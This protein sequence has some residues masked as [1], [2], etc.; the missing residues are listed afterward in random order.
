MSY[1]NIYVA[2]TSQ[3][4]G[5]TT[6]TLGLVHAFLNKSIDVG[7]CKPVGQ[8]FVWH[9]NLQ[10]DKDVV[11]F[12]DLMGFEMDPAVHS[13]VILGPNATSEFLENPAQFQHRER[14]LDASH[15]LQ[16]RHTLRIYEGTGH[17]GVG[18]AVNL[19][20]ADVAK[21]IDAQVIMIAEGGIGS[22]VDMLDMCMA[23]FR[24]RDVPIMGVILNKVLPEKTEKVRYHVG[25]WLEQRGI[26][27]LGCLPYDR[28]MSLPIMR[29]IAESVDGT[30][31]FFPE[32]DNNQIRN[33]IAGSLMSNDELSGKL[34]DS[35][36]VVGAARLDIAIAQVKDISKALGLEKSP[37]SG[38]LATGEGDFKRSTVQYIRKHKIPVVRTVLE[39][40]GAVLKISRI[41]V[42]INQ[43]TPWK[44]ARAIEMIESNVDLD[45]ILRHVQY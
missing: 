34:A 29:T 30:F 10:I 40:Y 42:K 45:Y 27:L 5:K 19:S 1:K 25:K 8:K 18:S 36:L 16:R 11:L 7:Y 17:P 26:P 28:T 38:I 33:I 20:N 23:L 44:V 32:R 14:L 39:T 12:S 21:I 6:S 9:Q 2:A 35:L 31:E 22:T 24:E 43:Q 13:P 4:V 41:E 15:E 3:H 37:F